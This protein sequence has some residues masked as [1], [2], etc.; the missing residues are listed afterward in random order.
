MASDEEQEARVA[1]RILRYLRDWYNQDVKRPVLVN[2]IAGNIGEDV[3]LVENYLEKMGEKGLVSCFKD[4]GGHPLCRILSSGIEHLEKLENKQTPVQTSSLKTD[5]NYM[6]EK[7]EECLSDLKKCKDTP[8]L[9]K[10][11]PGIDKT[12]EFHLLKI[13]NHIR[14]LLKIGFEDG[15]ERAEQYTHEGGEFYTGLQ[16]QTRPHLPNLTNSQSKFLQHVRWHEIKV[17]EYLDEL[18]LYRDTMPIS[19]IEDKTINDVDQIKIDL[20]FYI[21]EINKIISSKKYLHGVDVIVDL[22]EYLRKLALPQTT[23]QQ[24]QSKIDQTKRCNSSWLSMHW[25]KEGETYEPIETAYYDLITFLEFLM[26]NPTPL[27]FKTYKK[28]TSRDK[29]KNSLL[30][31]ISLFF[32]NRTQEKIYDKNTQYDI[33]KDLRDLVKKASKEV[34][35]VDSWIDETIFELYV[36]DIP[37]KVPVRILTKNYKPKFLTVAGMLVKKRS[38]EI[39]SN[40]DVVHDRYLFVDDKCFMLGSSIKDAGNRP[41]VITEIH[42]KDDMYKIWNNYFNCGTKIL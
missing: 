37:T 29:S 3:T 10:G 34:F 42:K 24:L 21:S 36:E 14:N 9:L 23:L 4:L 39:R 13:S 19:K 8:E 6:I 40:D 15:K 22:T 25:L 30:N 7:L 27:K 31:N 20:N 33:Y 5:V 28:I 17:N 26:N 1:K 41:T 35:I 11:L 38:L 12:N 18:I 32:K 16:Y 2:S